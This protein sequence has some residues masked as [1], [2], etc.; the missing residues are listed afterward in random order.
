[1][2]NRSRSPSPVYKNESPVY[3][4]N[5]DDVELGYSAEEDEVLNLTKEQKDEIVNAPYSPT[6]V[7]EPEYYVGY[8][9]SRQ[10]PEDGYKIVRRRDRSRDRHR[11]RSRSRS[12]SR[13]RDNGN[14]DFRFN[15]CRRCGFAG[16]SSRDCSTIQCSKCRGYGHR[17]R[18]CPSIVCMNCER[19]GHT[20]KECRERS[21]R[22]DHNDHNDRNDRNQ[23]NVRHKSSGSHRD[24]PYRREDRNNRNERNERNER[25]PQRRRY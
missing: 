21:G 18:D 20:S 17:Q 15:G 22:N 14:T 7:E 13:R 19:L 16:H 3:S 5:R 1:M 10:R 4:D 6:R 11:K 9:P 24:H 12:R 8:S 25:S 2:S 23:R